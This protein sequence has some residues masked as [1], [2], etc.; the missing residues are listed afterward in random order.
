MSDKGPIHWRGTTKDEQTA[1]GFAH[2]SRGGRVLLLIASP[3]NR[4]RL[5]EHLEAN[6]EVLTPVD[7]HFPEKPFDIAIVDS[8]GVTKWHRELEQA[9]EREQP[10]FLPCMLVVARADVAR[11][12]H[13]YWNVLD[14]F[15]ISPIDRGELTQRVSML[16]RAR[17]LA[18]V[19]Q[20]RL[21][22]LLHYDRATGLPNRRLFIERLMQAVRDASVLDQKVYATTLRIPLGGVL[23][24]LGARRLESAAQ[25]CSARLLDCLGEDL[26]LS[27]LGP[28]AWG[29]IFRA[30]GR[31]EEFL[32][33]CG[34]LRGISKYPV[35]VE[36]EKF[37]IAPRI[38]VAVYPND[39]STA[40][41]LFDH[42]TAALS[43]VDRPLVPTF[44][45]REVQTHALKYIRTEARLHEALTH[46]QF[47][48][49]LQPKWKIK[50]RKPIAAEALVRWRLP[51][52]ELVAPADFMMVA[53]TSGL[54]RQ[55]DRWVLNRACAAL[56][57]LRASASGIGR[58][59][60]NISAQD[61]AES[62]FVA[63]IKDVLAQHR[64]PPDS[65][66]LEMTETALVSAS[67][68]NL[69]KLRALRRLGVRLALDDFGTGY[70]S[71]SYLSNFPITT[72]KIDRCF[73]SDID[74][75]PNNATI[76]RCI[77]ALAHGFGLE[78]VAEGIETESQSS[79]LEELGV[80][81]GQ[82]FLVGRP[83]SEAEMKRS[84]ARRN[85]FDSN[86]CVRSQRRPVTKKTET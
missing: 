22:R 7:G 81:L 48:L 17:R 38:A 2:L 80:E 28:E 20:S 82:G 27:R 9:R 36:G 14:D 68:D 5:S 51:S 50:D 29:F 16:L 19:Q 52:G 74:C 64:I 54:V 67:T 11:G 8:A 18:I 33:V 42:A 47:E 63:F 4:R 69:D 56:R 37:H 45:S 13:P 12:P 61:I 58:V 76:A 44:Y 34:R 40:P 53:E 26:S 79:Y 72:L 25:L 23:K 70:S 65:L 77:V 62:D 15:L 1:G 59:A 21:A 75:N 32:E 84:L 78:I 46:E 49:W 31:V 30:P 55:I 86:S 60:V 39:A 71:L 3:G 66:E 57:S 43:Q 41:A 24:S 6:H 73:V 85:D 35:D 83:M 10:T